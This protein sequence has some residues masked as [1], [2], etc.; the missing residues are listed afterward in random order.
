MTCSQTTLYTKVTRFCSLLPDA[1]A[2][3]REA[4]SLPWDQGLV[5]LFPPFSLVARCLYGI[6]RGESAAIVFAPWWPRRG[7]FAQPLRLMVEP[8]ILLPQQGHVLT[9]PDGAPYPA[10]GMPDRLANLWVRSR[11]RAFL[12]RLLL[13]LRSIGLLFTTIGTYVTALSSCLG[14]RDG[15]IIGSHPLF[16]FLAQGIRSLPPSSEDRSTSLVSSGFV[17]TALCEAPHEPLRRA[18]PAVLTRE[19]AFLLAI[20]SARRMS[21]LHVFSRSEPWLILNPLLAVLTPP[22]EFR[23]MTVTAA[24]LDSCAE[25]QAFYPYPKNDL[26]GQ[27][28]K[29][30]PIRALH[31]YMKRTATSQSPSLLVNFTKGHEGRGIAKATLGSWITAV[32]QQSYLSNGRP[33][34]FKANPHTTRGVATSWAE[35]ARAAP[36]DICRAATWSTPLTFA[37]HYRL[38]FLGGQFGESVLSAATKGPPGGSKAM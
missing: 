21:E 20:P 2:T 31:Y 15:F 7:W 5:Y 3:G 12:R 8:P 23:P 29:C 24:A 10:L 11:Q 30:C 38:D 33:L 17:L 13:L 22:S 6:G 28:R 37:K 9:A 36:A 32:I 25:L 4:L 14:T 35:V 19:V 26:H 27:L 18:S 16:A 1:N 34:P